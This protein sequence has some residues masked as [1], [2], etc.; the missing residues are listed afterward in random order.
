M[1]RKKKKK[2]KKKKLNNTFSN[3]EKLIYLFK[4]LSEKQVNFLYIK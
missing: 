3:R 2:K 1:Y 4:G